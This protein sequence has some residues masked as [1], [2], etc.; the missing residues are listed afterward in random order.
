MQINDKRNKTDHF[1]SECPLFSFLN[2][3]KSRPATLKKTFDVETE[4][5][6]WFLLQRN[7][8]WFFN[9]YIK[10]MEF[11]ADADISSKQSVDPLWNADSNTQSILIIYVNYIWILIRAEDND[12]FLDVQ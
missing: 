6:I 2:A 1:L 7:Y 5:L 12:I 8:V 10:Q 4:L 11:F 9:G 3:Y